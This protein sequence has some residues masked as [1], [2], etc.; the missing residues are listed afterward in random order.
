[1][2]W[3]YNHKTDTAFWTENPKY[4]PDDKE[5]YADRSERRKRE[6]QQAEAQL[7][8]TGYP[9][10]E[11]VLGKFIDKND[12]SNSSQYRQMEKELEDVG[13]KID[14]ISQEQSKVKE[15]L[16][17]ETE[18]KP[19][20]EYDDKDRIAELLGEKPVKYT[21]VGEKLAKQYSEMNNTYFQLK[22]KASSLYSKIEKMDNEANKVEEA[23][24]QKQRPEYVKGSVDKS[25]QNFTT[26]SG[27]SGYNSD[28]KEGKGFIA[29]MS[30]KEYL[31]R[32]SYDVFHSSYS[33]TV[34]GVNTNDVMV[35][36]QMMKNGV[37]FD[38]P[39][40]ITKGSDIGD[41]E[42]RNRAMAAYLLGIKKIPVYVREK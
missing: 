35:Y 8:E 28:L 32:I 9:S 10:R 33:N 24:W 39:H 21:P 11:Q 37:K 1:M 36:Q 40:L 20:S 12:Y 27:V 30:P 17:R 25:Y 15:L 23:N 4:I 34:S 3:S 13:A 41:Q 18:I 14:K 42:G 22:K 26:I 7:A 6:R 2:A 31:Q 19:K 16:D 29:E 38:M 5:S